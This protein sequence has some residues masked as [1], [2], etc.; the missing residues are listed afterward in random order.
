[1]GEENEEINVRE[2]LCDNLLDLSLLNISTVPVDEIVCSYW[3]LG[4][5]R[6]G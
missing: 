2:R 5:A 4:A 3:S 1:M 6:T